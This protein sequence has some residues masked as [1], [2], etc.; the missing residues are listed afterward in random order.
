MWWLACLVLLQLA[1]IGVFV[2]VLRQD[3]GADAPIV[4]SLR[5]SSRAPTG[6]HAPS[7]SP[8]FVV[9]VVVAY[10]SSRAV[11]GDFMLRET[12]PEAVCE[13]GAHETYGCVHIA[14]MISTRTI[15]LRR[16]VRDMKSVMVSF[17]GGVVAHDVTDL[18][19]FVDLNL[20]ESVWT[21]T[22]ESG[23][24]GEDD[25]EDWTSVLGYGVYGQRT[26]RDGDARCSDVK[27]LMC[28]CRAHPM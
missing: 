14:A 12:S 25:C 8:T 18:W 1:V 5:G 6:T 17:G 2:A 10:L 11:R 19:T 3:E 15:P 27:R 21:G 23:G 26:L 20:H 16:R 28:A 9:P 4:D 22:D 13:E 24:L 7:A